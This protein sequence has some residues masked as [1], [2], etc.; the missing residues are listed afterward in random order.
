MKDCHA[1]APPPPPLPPV[2]PW[3]WLVAHGRSDL[4]PN[5]PFKWL[6][7]LPGVMTVYFLPYG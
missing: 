1:R 2:G 3:P 4:G 7:I 5:I 6:C